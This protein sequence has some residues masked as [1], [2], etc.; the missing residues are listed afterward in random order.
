[1]S[2]KST[3]CSDLV[4]LAGG[5]FHETCSCSY[6]SATVGGIEWHIWDTPALND[7]ADIENGWAGEDVLFEADVVLVC[8]DGRHAG[9]MDLVDACGRDRC[10]IALTRGPCAAV[11][12]SYAIRYLQSPCSNGMLVPRAY[13]RGRLAYSIRML[14]AAC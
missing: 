1:M 12:V 13:G 11:D 14:L 7:A 5:R 10:V 3:T 4:G 6:L 8:H 2:G 9:P